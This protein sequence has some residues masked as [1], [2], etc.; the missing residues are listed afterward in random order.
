[1]LNPLKDETFSPDIAQS[2]VK[3]A[4][5]RQTGRAASIVDPK[6]ESLYTYS[7]IEELNGYVVKKVQLAQLFLEVDKQK[8]RFLVDLESF[9]CY[10]FY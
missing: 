3:S 4:N 10:L 5:Q 8:R 6:E 7:Y 9:C 1:M 2:I